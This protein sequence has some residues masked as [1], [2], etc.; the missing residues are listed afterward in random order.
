MKRRQHLLFFSMV[1]VAASACAHA[2][3]PQAGRASAAAAG[4]A[5]Y[6][7]TEIRRICLQNGI[8]GVG[9]GDVV[10][11]VGDLTAELS[12]SDGDNLRR[13]ITRFLSGAY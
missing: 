6:D 2:G 9:G 11:L 13:E 1:A 8:A 5:T 7:G 12:P 4:E 3:S 10:R